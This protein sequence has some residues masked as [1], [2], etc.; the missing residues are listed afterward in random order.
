M[1]PDLVGMVSPLA[2]SESQTSKCRGSETQRE[3]SWAS[4]TR[5]GARRNQTPRASRVLR[6][7]PRYSASS[8]SSVVGVNAACIEHLCEVQAHAIIQVANRDEVAH[9]SLSST[10]HLRVHDDQLAVILRALLVQCTRLVPDSRIND[11]R[12]QVTLQFLSLR[13]SEL[14]QNGQKISNSED[15]SYGSCLQ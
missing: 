13:R 1:R 10:L 14:R 4:L 8:G 7:T 9:H 5:L 3:G 2:P 15:L 12:V 11:C 6:M